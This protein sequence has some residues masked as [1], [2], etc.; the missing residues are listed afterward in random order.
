MQGFKD[1]AEYDIM[2]YGND[3]LYYSGYYETKLRQLDKVKQ[4]HIYRCALLIKDILFL[5]DFD[6]DLDLGSYYLNRSYD[7]L[8]HMTYNPD[9]GWHN[10]PSTR[11]VMNLLVKIMLRTDM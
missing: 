10:M 2:E 9:T 7:A 3:R 11:V 1:L 4:Q 6:Y 8:S 5:S